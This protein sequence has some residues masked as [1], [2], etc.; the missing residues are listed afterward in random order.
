MSIGLGMFTTESESRMN[1][2]ILHLQEHLQV[3]THSEQS[4]IRYML[5]HKEQLP[6][7]SIQM[8][9]TE[10]YTS[11]ASIIRLCHKLGFDSF[12][13]FKIA[14]TTE[15][16][17]RFD[18]LEQMD[19]TINQSDNLEEIAH[20]ITFMNI[21]SLEKTI[22]LLDNDVLMSCV[23]LINECRDI[24]FFGI[25]VSYSVAR[26]AY[27]KF[28][29]INKPCSANEDWHIQMVQARN[30]T[31]ESLGIVLSYSG[32]TVEMVECMKIMKEV[33]CPIIS[34]TRHDVNPVSSL[35]DHRLY[36]P[37]IEST[38]RTGAMSSRI[39]QLNLIDI[40]YTAYTNLDYDFIMKRISNTHVVKP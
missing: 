9:A 34:I 39:S 20:K 15:L 17:Q 7:M 10:T 27:M 24:V 3:G 11:T 2:V 8:I 5:E 33:G 22:S 26:D 14:I 4:I 32:H 40:L 38:F 21:M 37:A 13:T 12:K 23:Q 18:S 6:S 19:H 1:N 29:R 35:A 25:G 30:M 16:S 31:K 36:V 28:L